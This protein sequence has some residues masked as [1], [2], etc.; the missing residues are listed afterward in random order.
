MGHAGV[1]QVR[2]S[3]D[4]L[5]DELALGAGTRGAS[6][7]RGPGGGFF[8][9]WTESGQAA[10]KA[11]ISSIPAKCVSLETPRRTLSEN[12]FSRLPRWR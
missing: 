7:E 10:S 11:D 5:A 6:G 1:G 4:V 9:G 2:A 8:G 3:A 12:M